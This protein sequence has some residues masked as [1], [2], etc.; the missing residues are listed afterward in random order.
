VRAVETRILR[1]IGLRLG[2]GVRVVR[3]RSRVFI[4]EGGAAAAVTAARSLGR[5]GYD[6]VV[7][8]S[9]KDVPLA[10][11][12]RYCRGVVALPGAVRQPDRYAE[13]VLRTVRRE[14]CDA[15]LS[16]SDASLLALTP[17]RAAIEEH[18]AFCAAPAAALA[19]AW[20]KWELVAA[21]ARRGIASPPS[22]LVEH[23]DDWPAARDQVG[24]PCVMRGRTSFVRRPNGLVKSPTS[25]HFH[26]PDAA[27]S[28]RERCDRGESFVVSAFTQGRGRGVYLFIAGGRA[29]VWFGHERIRETDPRGGPAC[30]ARSCPPSPDVVSKCAAM[31][32]EW[33]F[34][35]AAM[36]EF[37]RD[38]VAGQD[39]LVEVN[40]RLWGSLALSAHAGVD[41]PRYQVDYFVRGKVPTMPAGVIPPMGARHLSSEL[42]HLAH[43]WQGR[44]AGWERDYPTFR[45][46]LADF[47][48]GFHDGLR[49]Y[50]QSLDDPLPGLVE[51]IASLVAGI[52]H[53]AV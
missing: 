39:W 1:G 11:F 43:A 17:V 46:A 41:F 50:H 48:A 42:I 2:A 7:G 8:R 29:H 16:V 26:E 53:E 35:G 45:G 32:A 4:P 21:G 5:A 52:R 24:V 12:S 3:F 22:A 30:A 49:Y 38:P 9:P 19:A 27:R 36:V 28:A 14:E 34:E 51:P 6:V 20:D 13:A 18:A 33:G 23:P 37:R 31:L 10:A 25:V 47:T 15:V 44:P 40:P